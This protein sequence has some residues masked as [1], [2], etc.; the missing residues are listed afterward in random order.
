MWNT[1]PLAIIYGC[2][3]LNLLDLSMKVWQAIK[4]RHMYLITLP[5]LFMHIFYQCYL[6]K[7][8]EKD[9]EF[10]LG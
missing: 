6:D 4:V 3:V 1:Y 7:T 8:F 5:D 2:Y 9:L 10:A